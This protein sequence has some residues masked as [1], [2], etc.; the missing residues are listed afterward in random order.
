MSIAQNYLIGFLLNHR[1]EKISL[2]GFKI[3]VSIFDTRNKYRTLKSSDL[4]SDVK[5]NLFSLLF[6]I[7]SIQSPIKNQISFKLS[8]VTHSMVSESH[9]YRIVWGV[10]EF[11]NAGYKRDLF[12]ATTV[13]KTEIKI[14][15]D[16]QTGNEEIE[17]DY[18]FICIHYLYKGTL[19]ARYAISI[20]PNPMPVPS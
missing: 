2:Y 13:I 11:N 14:T 16:H 18:F 20:F 12:I 4:I 7:L 5:F 15:T 3:T 17:N 8:S 6:Q 10:S 19:S 9:K 1:P